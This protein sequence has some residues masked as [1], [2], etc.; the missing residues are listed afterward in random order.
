MAMPNHCI[1]SLIMSASTLPEII[2]KYLDKDEKGNLIFDFERIVPIGDVPDWQE[3]RKEKWGT[4]WIGY[5]VSVNEYRIDFFTAWTP[6]LPILKKLAELHNYLVFRL[7][8]SEPGIGFQGKAVAKWGDEE[9][10][11][12]DKCWNMTGESIERAEESPHID[13]E[14]LFEI[15]ADFDD[16]EAATEAVQVVE[17]NSLGPVDAVSFLAFCY[18][19]EQA[20][21]KTKEEQ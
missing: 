13:Y 2:S 12:D 9:V 15:W 21:N 19:Y 10:L 16:A 5:N 7:E 4:K 14:K 20:L 8:Y 3:Q 1:N 11:F 6:P 17:T 18:G